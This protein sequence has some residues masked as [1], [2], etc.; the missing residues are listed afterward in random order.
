L[1]DLEEIFG[2]R[3]SIEEV[4]RR[5]CTND[6]G[7]LPD[8]IGIDVMDILIDRMPSAVVQPVTTEE[9]VELVK[10]A[11]SEKVP[12]TPRAAASS[13]AGGAVPTKGGIAVD[14]LRMNEI[15]EIDKEKMTARVQ[16]GVIWNRLEEA[17]NEEGL[18]LRAYPTSAPSSAVGGWVGSGGIG[19]GSFEYGG[20]QENIV[21]LELARPN[22]EVRLM[23]GDDLDL[24]VDCQG[25]TGIVTEVTLKVKPH[26][27]IV[28]AGI[29]FDSMEKMHKALME[30][31]GRRP[32]GSGQAHADPRHPQVE[33][34][35]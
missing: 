3:L 5:L 23:A 12:L 32:R 13:G 28:P 6:V 9:V 34:Q 16:P 1:K 17:L 22:G 26:E 14:L 31:M 35:G 29:G 18:E 10:F 25:I 15:L 11:T 24:V 8:I 4:E 20:V 33:I 30:I 21:S 7:N 2:D 27:P 19:I